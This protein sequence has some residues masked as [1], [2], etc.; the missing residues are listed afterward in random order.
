ME[1]PSNV[2]P[3]TMID[4]N[5][6]L[7][8]AL[9]DVCHVLHQLYEGKGS[10]KGVLIAL[11]Q[12]G[13]I[14]QRK[15]TELLGIRPGSVSEVIA[16]LEYH[17]LISRNSNPFDGRTVDIT[18]TAEGQRQSTLA[19]QQRIRRHDEM[20]SCLSEQEKQQL[21]DL[22]GKLN[23][24]WGER[25]CLKCPT[26]FYNQPITLPRTSCGPYGHQPPGEP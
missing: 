17:G 12:T 21:Q 1:Q 22:L 26:S 23:Q 24:A 9:R 10:Q 19:R 13:P 7:V 3:D 20:F 6:D 14:T 4:E 25:C 11:G 8:L 5:L 18:L 15:L 2:Q 16:K